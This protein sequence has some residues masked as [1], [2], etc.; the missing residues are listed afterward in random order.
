VPLS[1]EDYDQVLA[2]VVALARPAAG[3]RVL[4]LGTGT[5]NLATRFLEAGC[6]V[7]GVDFSSQM[8]AQARGKLPQLHAVEADLLANEWPEALARRYDRIVSAYALHDLDLS[9][10]VRLLVR[11]AEH[12][13]AKEGS[14]VFADVSYPDRAARAEAQARWGR[15]WGEKEHY[16]AAD[17]TIAACEDMGLRCAYTQVSSCGGVFLIH[18]PS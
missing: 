14:M 1:F 8:L 11:L 18:V 4:D 16:W 5:G 12:H 7:W 10:K 6:E 15:L 13:L 2:A 3:M 17:E 9:E